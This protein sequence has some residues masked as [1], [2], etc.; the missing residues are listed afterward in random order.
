MPL[1][2][3]PLKAKVSPSNRPMNCCPPIVKTAMRDVSNDQRVPLEGFCE[4]VD[5]AKQAFHVQKDHVPLA[6]RETI[7]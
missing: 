7:H 2:P 4:V 1:R 3:S 5:P 6:L